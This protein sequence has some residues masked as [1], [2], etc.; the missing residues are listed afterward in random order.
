MKYFLFDIGMVLVEFDLQ[1]FLDAVSTASGKPCG[2]LA[3]RDLEMHDAVERGEISD[4]AWVDYLNESFGM[5]WAL[6]DLVAC[7]SHM[8]RLHEPGRALFG[9]MMQA[10]VNIETLSNI[11]PFHLDAIERNWSGFFA[12]CSQRLC[13]FRLGRR[14]PDP[15]IYR[16]ALEVLGAAGSDCFFIDD[17]MENIDAARAA[18]M[19]A[20]QYAPENLPQIRRAAVAFFELDGVLR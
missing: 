11:A 19:Q 3:G 20:Y 2:P 13:S 16:R 8:F 1:E 4:Q 5:H 14:K 10:G 7:W 6:D 9:E 12:G 18:G 17:R 15:E